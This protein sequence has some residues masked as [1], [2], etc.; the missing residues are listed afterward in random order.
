M[1]KAFFFLLLSLIFFSGCGKSESDNNAYRDGELVRLQTATKG[2][3]IDLLIMGDGFTMEDLVFDGKYVRA[4]EQ[5]ADY[6]FTAEPFSSYRDYFNVYMAVVRSEGKGV[7]TERTTV[8][9]KFGS[10]I[11]SSTSTHISFESTTCYNYVSRLSGL[12]PMK[13]LTVILVLNTTAYAGTCY[14]WSN[15][16]SIALCPMSAERVP[17][18]F[19]GVVCHEAAG[20]GFAKLADEYVSENTSITEEKKAELLKNQRDGYFL[21]VDLTDDLTTIL[22]NNFIGLPGYSGVGAYEGAYFYSR[23]V[24]RP[25]RYSCMDNNV[26]YFN[27]PSRWLAVQRIMKITG[28][29][30]AFN[31]FLKTDV[32][33]F[34]GISFAKTKGGEME[35][36]R[37]HPPVWVD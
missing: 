4:M 16:F 11:T 32:I 28:Q 8:R 36:P 33:D 30:F 14:C 31:D 37:L 27:A 29:A 17:Y 10:K 34:S 9:N 7:S 22:W 19:K 35:M 20:H 13:D 26:G 3:G 12:A 24:W 18:D 25:E 2:S 23:G 1:R 15:G 5:A 6:F 21:N